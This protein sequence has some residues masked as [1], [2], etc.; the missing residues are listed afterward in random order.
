VSEGTTRC[1]RCGVITGEERCPRCGPISDVEET[2]HKLEASRERLSAWRERLERRLEEVE[3]K[4]TVL[5]RP[6]ARA[7][8][9]APTRRIDESPEAPPEASV[10]ADSLIAEPPPSSDTTPSADDPPLTEPAPQPRFGS[11]PTPQLIESETVAEGRPVDPL[12]GD[13]IGGLP[14]SRQT[15]PLVVAVEA[16]DNLMLEDVD[17]LPT[18]SIV[19]RAASIL[20]DVV[21][22]LMLPAALVTFPAAAWALDSD[23]ATAWAVNAGRLSPYF[24]ALFV[25]LHSLFLGA[26]GRTPGMRLVGVRVVDD[27]GATPSFL[28]AMIRAALLPML[29]FAPIERMTGTRA[30]SE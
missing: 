17:D 5:E 19:L 23:L 27:A 15:G 25:L 21:A 29:L 28:I 30:I 7:A 4:R 22:L 1:S 6:E 14:D 3:R 2:R 11:M 8:A 20:L 10:G 9:R 12:S 26:F 24:L 18:P 13:L 16:S